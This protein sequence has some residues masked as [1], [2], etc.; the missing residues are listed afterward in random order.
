MKIKLSLAAALGAAAIAAPAHAGEL[1]GGVYRHAVDTPFTLDTQEGG[2]DV[3][4]GYRLDPVL[5]VVGIEPY[6]FGSVNSESG[7]TDFVGA[8]I[9]RKFSLGGVY[10]R[11]GVGL[12]LHNAPSLRTNPDT[13]VRTDLGSRVLFEPEIAIGLALAPRVSVEASWVHISNARLFNSQQNPGID[14]IGVR[15]NLK[16]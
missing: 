6:V 15:A 4:V 10:V 3:Q 9:S 1:Y 11:P 12:V 14:L 2:V 8:G 5:P 13:G 16:L 7:G